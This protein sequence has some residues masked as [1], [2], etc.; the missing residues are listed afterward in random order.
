MFLKMPI[1]QAVAK[2]RTYASAYEPEEHRSHPVW[3]GE[4]PIE[5]RIGK[6]VPDPTLDPAV[7]EGPDLAWYREGARLDQTL[8]QIRRRA[9]GSKR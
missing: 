4:V 8:L 6:A 7:K 2:V 9:R 3:A 5:T 1:D